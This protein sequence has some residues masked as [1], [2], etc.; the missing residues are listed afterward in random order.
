MPNYWIETDN[1]WVITEPKIN[2][3][4]INDIS[5]VHRVDNSIHL[6]HYIIQI[7]VIFDAM[8]I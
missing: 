2:I 4:E 8:N 7:I 5:V 1:N 3:N 6:L